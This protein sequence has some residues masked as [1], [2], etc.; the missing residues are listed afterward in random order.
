MDKKELAGIVIERLKKEYPGAECTLDYDEAWKLLVS[1]R[2]AAQCTDE[3]VN[4]I[5]PSLYEKFPSIDALANADVLTGITSQKVTNWDNAATNS[6]VH[7]NKALLDTYTQTESNLADAVSKK[8]N[9]AN[10]AALETITTEKIADWDEA[11]ASAHTHDNKT[12]LDGITTAETTNWNTAFN[13]VTAHTADT[14]IHVTTAQ[15]ANWDAAYASAHT[16]ANQSVLYID[17]GTY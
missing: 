3:R 12:V 16:H 15:T 7:S 13:T 6:H 11:A 14:N 4:Q 10:S 1:V 5:V 8:H 17:C 2:L 9:H